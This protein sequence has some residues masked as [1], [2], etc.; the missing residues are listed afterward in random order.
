PLWFLFLVLSTALLAVHTLVPPT[1]FVLPGQLFPVWPEWHEA[2]AV[3]LCSATA[4]LLFLPKLLS[5]VHALARGGRGYGGA[6]RLGA[7]VAA[8]TGVSVLLAPVRM[9]FHTQ[10][11]LGALTGWSVQWKSP[12]RED[13]ETTWAEAL[14]RHGAHSVLGL[15]WA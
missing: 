4:A 13:A 8:E 3:A 10:F 5:I 14:R 9:L 1:Y 12:P 6:L 11:V 2:W 15:T 7:S